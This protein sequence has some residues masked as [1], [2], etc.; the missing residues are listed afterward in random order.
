MEIKT[1]ALFPSLIW[2]TLFDDFEQFNPPLL[3]HALAL[4]ERDPAGVQKSNQAGWQ[5]DNTLQALPEF[6]PINTRIIQAA[7]A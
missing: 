5:S 2:S 4:R 1:Q 3:Q 7:S 6:E